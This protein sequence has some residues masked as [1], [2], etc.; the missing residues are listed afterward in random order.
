MATISVSLPSDGQTIDAADVNS[1][2]NTIVAAINGNLDDDNIKT[3]ANINGSKLL[4][5]SVSPT[6]G[7]ADMRG[8]WNTGILPAPNT[9]T[10]NGNR[11]YSLVFNSTDL[12]SYISPGMRVRTTRTVAAPTQSASLNG[13][14]QYFDRTSASL[15][16]IT[17]TDDFVCS[18]WVKVNAYGSAQTIVSRYNATSGWQFTMESNG[19]LALYGHKGGSGNQSKITSYQ[20]LPLN[21]WVHVAAQLDMSAFSNS[22][23]TSYVMINGVNVPAAVVRLGTNPTDLT[24]AGNLEVGS[25]N[26]GSQPFNGK[27]AQ[28]AVFSAKVTQATIQSYISQGLSGSETSLISAYSLNNSL[29]DLNTTNANN[30]TAQNSATAT[31]DDSPFGGQASGTISSTLDYGIVMSATFSTDTTLVVQVPEGCTIPTSGGVTA[32]AYS[33]HKA[34]YGMP[35]SEHRWTI[36]SIQRADAFQSFPTANTWYNT[37]SFQIVVPIGYW[38]ITYSVNTYIIN[39]VGTPSQLVTFSTANNSESDPITTLQHRSPYNSTISHRST[40]NRNWKYAVTNLTTYYINTKSD[41]PSA[42]DVGF[43]SSTA[44]SIA[45]IKPAFL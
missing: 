9:V 7:D 13:S 19:Q 27:L 25:A 2:I 6:K 5:N 14:N 32:V 39:N 33:V 12:T 30:L 26:G 45:T 42:T 40:L 38:D 36:S 16:G 1:P 35:I 29:T 18:A 4:A 22:A 20:S 17:F 24:Q 44:A 31:D 8:G 28:V 37:G 34:P 15:T 3:G 43:A 10:Y 11:S 41:Q 23:T 21:R